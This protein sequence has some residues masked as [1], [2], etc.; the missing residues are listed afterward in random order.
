MH[1]SFSED[2]LYST[3][4]LLLK[5]WS[6]QIV[7]FKNRWICE[8]LVFARTFFSFSMIYRFDIFH[9]CNLELVRSINAV[10]K[11]FTCID[12]GT[13]QVL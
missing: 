8:N 2:N 1:M 13:G 7:L 11:M 3:K 12:T 6:H 4:K 5:R 10:I 9:I